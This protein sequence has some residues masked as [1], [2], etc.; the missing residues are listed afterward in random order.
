MKSRRFVLFGALLALMAILF[1]WTRLPESSVQES[2]ESEP[3]QTEDPSSSLAVG[4]I[5]EIEGADSLSEVVEPVSQ[6]LADGSFGGPKPF[7]SVSMSEL[8]EVNLANAG[9]QHSH[10]IRE[11]KGR[12]QPSLTDLKDKLE[13]EGEDGVVAITL[14]DATQVQ[15]T[16]MRFESFGGN[17]GVITG[18][19]LGDTFGEVV[20]SYVNQ[21][22]AGSIHDHQNDAV[23]E[24]RN[25]GDGQQYIAQVDVSALGECGVCK[26]EREQ[27]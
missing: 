26:A 21:A 15:V 13:S 7:E 12:I 24:I 23:W 10:K 18:K 8:V 20:L 27:R 3:R 9:E 2:V 11:W 6:E 17:Q 5:E 14:P 22:V 1:F 4:E 16:R 19:I 25:A